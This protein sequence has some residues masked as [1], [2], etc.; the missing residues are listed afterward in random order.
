MDND[1]DIIFPSSCGYSCVA[2]DGLYGF[3]DENH[4]L[5]V[6][7][8]YE[9]AFPYLDNYAMVCRDGLWGFI[10]IHGKEIVPMKYDT[11]YSFSN[12]LA[13]YSREG[14]YGYVNKK[15]VEV[16]PPIYDDA[17]PFSCSFAKVKKNGKWGYIRV[18][19]DVVIPLLYNDAHNCVD[20][21][22]VVNQGGRLD[23][24]WGVTTGGK[25]FVLN[26]KGKR[27]SREYTLISNYINGFAK[28]NIGGRYENNDCFMGGLWGILNSRGEECVPLV[29]EEMSNIMEGIV[30]VKKEG[31]FG[32]INMSNDILIPIKYDYI[33]PIS[34]GE[35][36]AVCDG[37]RIYI[38]RD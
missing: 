22:M 17:L 33:S 16:V 36:F 20:G 6:P 30:K 24:K 29:Y 1:Y 14:C 35:T 2:R 8:V 27:I 3:I 5:I 23:K 12:E 26:E 10:D 34:Y 11:I 38:Q 31:K 4:R 37:E 28:V 19:G 15:G 13:C 21:L 7:L 25:W 32:M 9:R 18:N